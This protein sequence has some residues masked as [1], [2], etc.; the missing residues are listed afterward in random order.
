M[1]PSLARKRYK[2]T[3]AI[4]MLFYIVTIFAVSI[5]IAKTDVPNMAKYVLSCLPIIFVWWFLWGFIRFF[6]E[7]DEYERSR[8]TT[9]MLVGVVVI[10]LV[11]S[12][13]G[14][15][16]MLAD[17]PPLPVFWIFPMYFLASGLAQ[18]F[19]KSPGDNC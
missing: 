11:T 10:M 5:Y 18:Q 12:G 17:A 9:S 7:T 3:T 6:K 2:K 8:L 4:S 16:E 15:M 1:N 19:T 14:F 13:W